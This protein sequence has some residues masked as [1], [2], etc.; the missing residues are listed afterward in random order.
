MCSLHSYIIYGQ[1]NIHVKLHHLS[2]VK[3]VL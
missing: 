3:L 1:K 2:K